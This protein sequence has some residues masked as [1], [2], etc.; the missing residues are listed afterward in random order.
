MFFFMSSIFCRFSRSLNPLTCKILI[1]LTIVDFPDSPAPK[2]NNRCVARYTCLSFCS[3]LLI[4]SLILFCDLVSSAAGVESL[5]PKQPMA[6]RED[7]QQPAPFSAAPGP[8]SGPVATV[9]VV[10]SGPL[11]PGASSL[12][13]LVMSPVIPCSMHH[14]ERIWL[15]GHRTANSNLLTYVGGVYHSTTRIHPKFKIQYKNGSAAYYV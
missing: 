12:L 6:A 10:V 4:W 3:C 13:H 9:A 7:H 1:C 15:R 11:T 8:H 2:S 5:L 14:K